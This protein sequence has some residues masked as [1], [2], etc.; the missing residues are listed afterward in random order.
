MIWD[1]C[2]TRARS[3]VHR[4]GGRLGAVLAGPCV[5]GLLHCAR[6][7]T[8]TEFLAQRA[9][10]SEALQRPRFMRK[11]AYSL[12]PSSIYRAFE[13]RRT[14]SAP[15][16]RASCGFMATIV[17]K[18]R[19]DRARTVAFGILPRPVRDACGNDAKLVC[20]SRVVGPVYGCRARAARDPFRDRFRV[21]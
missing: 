21:R 3:F 19:G 1:G 18:L 10:N 2:L 12:Q 13:M 20:D 15:V 6:R 5:H 11:R 4:L 7:L 14:S 17:R 8:S 16:V 9:K